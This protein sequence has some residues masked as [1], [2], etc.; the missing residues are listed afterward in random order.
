ME[1]RYTEIKQSYIVKGGGWDS[2]PFYLQ[3]GVCQ[4]F[5]A[6]AAHSFVGFRYVVY[7]TKK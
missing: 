1:D 4:F 3:T 6:D 2:N 7:V 5:P